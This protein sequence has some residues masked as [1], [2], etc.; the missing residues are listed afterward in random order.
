YFNVLIPRV[1]KFLRERNLRITVFLSG[2]DAAMPEHVDLIRSI[3]ADGHE[4][5][6][7]SFNAEPW[8]VSLPASEVQSEIARAEEQIEDISGYHPVGFRGPGCII[9]HDILQVLTD[10]GYLYDAS[11][12]PTYFGTAAR[13]Y[14]FKAVKLSAEEHEQR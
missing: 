10:R 8:M 3:T 2:Q 9:S 4:I 12:L 11:T 6:N 13:P 5:G 7:Y 14:R 1:L